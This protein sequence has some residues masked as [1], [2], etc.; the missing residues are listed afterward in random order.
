VQ[1]NLEVGVFTN[2]ITTVPG[3]KEYSPRSNR[4]P[5]AREIFH[6]ILKDLPP[7]I[8]AKD[9]SSRS[10][11]SSIYPQLPEAMET[12]L[13]AEI[14]HSLAS[15]GGRENPP[16]RLI[17]GFEGISSVK[18]KLKTVS[19]ELEDFIEVSEQ[20]DIPREGGENDDQEPDDQSEDEDK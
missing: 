20:V 18:E 15:I 9:S 8:P 12:S 3:L 5:L 19:E 14:V 1:P 2:K 10:K 13:T 7:G 4:A 17:V 6:R 16:A 11:V